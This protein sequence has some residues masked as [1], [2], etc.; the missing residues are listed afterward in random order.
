MTTSIKPHSTSTGIPYQDTVKNFNVDTKIV[1]NTAVIREHT[2][3]GIVDSDDS[4]VERIQREVDTKQ[5]LISSEAQQR[6][7]ELIFETEQ[8]LPSEQRINLERYYTPIIKSLSAKHVE[9]CDAVEEFE[10]S[11]TAY[12]A[13]VQA[14]YAYHLKHPDIVT[15]QVAGDHHF[16]TLLSGGHIDIEGYRLVERRSNGGGVS[17]VTGNVMPAQGSFTLVYI[18]ISVPNLMSYAQSPQAIA[19]SLHE[20]NR[21]LQRL[22]QKRKQAAIALS[23]AKQSARDALNSIQSFDDLISDSVKRAL[24]K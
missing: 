23:E 16:N 1:G 7:E 4:L 12:R 6:E 21:D 22:I 15:K 10:S 13:K 20:Y 3:V 11:E 17:M 8:L 19:A 2:P 18:P 5:S 14:E 9:A 24:K